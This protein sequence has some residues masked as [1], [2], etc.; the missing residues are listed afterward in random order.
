MSLDTARYLPPPMELRDRRWRSFAA[1]A[2]IL[3]AAFALLSLLA[4]E[5]GVRLAATAVPKWDW[6]VHA[7]GLALLLLSGAILLRARSRRWAPAAA[8]P[9]L[10]WSALVLVERFLVTHGGWLSRLSPT[11]VLLLLLAVATTL[12]A[13]ER[14]L[15]LVLV[16]ATGLGSLAAVFGAAL[17]RPWPPL[18]PGTRLMDPATAVCLALL[19]AAWLCCE[20]RLRP[21]WLLREPTTTGWLMR[22]A[23][24][25]LLVFPILLAWL[26]GPHS[27]FTAYVSLGLIVLA[28][29]LFGVLMVMSAQVLDELD[30]NRVINQEYAREINDLYNQAPC[31][32]H[33]LDAAGLIIQ[34]NDTELRWLGYRRQ[35][36][37]HHRRFA[38]LVAPESRDTFERHF[39]AVIA[40]D[41][42]AEVELDL[43]QK[44]GTLLPAAISATAVR[45]PD[46]RFICTRTTIFDVTQ[47][48]QAEAALRRS[49][50]R[51]RAIVNS[52]ADAIVGLAQDGSIV[53]F[54]PAAE[55]LFGVRAS[56]ARQFR[57]AELIA[58]G[59]P[60]RRQPL[61]LLASSEQSPRHIQFTA[62]RIDGAEFPAELTLARVQGEQPDLFTAFVRD[63]TQRQRA[64]AELRGSEERLRLLLDSTG[65]GIYALDLDGR[66]TLCNPAA[67]HLLGYTSPSEL[68][69]RSLHAL[70]HHTRADGTRYPAH[71]CKSFLAAREGRSI[72]VDDEIFWR[73]DGNALAVDYRSYP[74]MRQGQIIGVVV[75][76]T[77]N[78]RRR[79]LEDQLRQSQKME[80]IGRLAA[81]VAHDF[82]NLL[83]VINGYSDMLLESAT[84]PEIVDKLSAI[85]TA[86][87]RAANLTHQLLA[88]SRQQV[89]Q[90]RALDLNAVLRSLKPLLARTLGE[91]VSFV[92]HLASDLRPVYVDPSQID[93][94]V[95]NLVMNARDALA[96]G[97]V[98]QIETSNVELNEAFVRSHPGLTAGSYVRLSVQDSGTGMR[99]ETKTHMFE[100]FFTTKPQ[101]RG[102]GLGLPTVFGV[103]RQSGGTVTVHSQWGHGTTVEVYLPAFDLPAEAAAPALAGASAFARLRHSETVLIVEDEDELRRLMLEVLNERGYRVLEARRPDQALLLSRHHLG[104][105]HLLITDLVLPAMQGQVLAQKLIEQR[106]S[107]RVLYISGYPNPN[108][109]SAP[110]PLLEK[111]FGPEALLN[112]VRQLLD[113]GKGRPPVTVIAAAAST[114]PN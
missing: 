10:V 9:A 29:A 15:A 57:G 73:R 92:A 72:E 38:D 64:E 39:A 98:I 6:A 32:Y 28:F 40:S 59:S 1:A 81:G 55:T 18:G 49:E 109:E 111:P 53:D 97:G 37:L 77:D 7:T 60:L 8:L 5:P 104:E 61:A 65:E 106:P 68:L 22:R 66:C 85:R 24:G 100:P 50:A 17:E 79:A 83:T 70:I 33:S 16:S 4:S 82:N 36:L 52:A 101:G 89:L 13:P 88:F 46:G 69:G 105:L 27:S 42:L 58:P 2:A 94:V 26:N 44:D 71:E 14:P 63:L 21:V 48:R 31:G 86:G 112:A 34:I 108:P 91:S 19:S 11:M 23:L 113:A 20:P 103:A 114:R 80:A 107:L 99:D 84:H 90:P 51:N 56:E 76:F 102:T 96:T 35:E 75:T 110:T 54:N 87:D 95:M 93:Q 25:L 47:R 43:R 3:C 30:A 62:R 78:T 74:V 12:A 41:S 67:V 45:H